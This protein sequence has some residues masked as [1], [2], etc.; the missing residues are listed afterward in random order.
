MSAVLLLAAGVPEL[1]LVMF[2]ELQIDQVNVIDSFTNVFF[3]KD[4]GQVML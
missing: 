4:I 1:F 2:I 3:H